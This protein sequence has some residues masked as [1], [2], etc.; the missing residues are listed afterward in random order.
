[1]LKLKFD[2]QRDCRGYVQELVCGVM[3]LLHTATQSLDKDPETAMLS[4]GRASS[5]LEAELNRH[6]DTGVT[7]SASGALLAWQIR[8]VAE[9]IDK[10]ISSRIRVSHLSKLLGRS[11]AHFSRGFKISFGQTPHTY[12]LRRRMELAR[13]FM[14]VSDAP[15]SEISLRCGLTDQAHLCNAFRKEE[16][17]TPAAWRRERITPREF[18]RSALRSESEQ[19]VNHNAY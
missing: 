16:G 10:H 7:E 19:G 9:Y 17:Q 1:M 5:L 4:I 12:I 8:R 11:D 18:K 3:A 13:H 14:L 6:V 2:E 15:L